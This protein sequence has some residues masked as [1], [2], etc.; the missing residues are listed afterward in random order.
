M[1][2][3][4]DGAKA[5]SRR[6]YGLESVKKTPQVGTVGKV[7][8]CLSVALR[9]GAST[10]SGYVIDDG[11]RNETPGDA[12]CGVAGLGAGR[13]DRNVLVPEP[14]RPQASG[15]RPDPRR[16]R[17]RSGGQGQYRR[18]GIPRQLCFLS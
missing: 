4:V 9:P 14:G 15:G 3:G 13:D 8:P 18:L 2:T 1:A 6:R 17:A 11:P 5:V 16:D 10:R 12:G 7:A